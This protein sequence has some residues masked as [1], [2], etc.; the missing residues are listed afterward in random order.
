MILFLRQNV[1]AKN[2]NPY[3]PELYVRGNTRDIGPHYVG[4]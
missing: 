3:E 4:S 2:Y 1:G